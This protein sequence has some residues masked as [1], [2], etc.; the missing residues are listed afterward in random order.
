MTQEF[1]RHLR[2]NFPFYT[3][4]RILIAI[5]G[6]IDSVVLASL[7]RTVS[8][9]IALAHCNFAL[10]GEESDADEAFVKKLGGQYDIP[11]FTKRFDTEK[12][13]TSEKL[14][15]QMAA[16]ELRYNWF[17]QLM[18][19]HGYDYL[20]TAH[21]A[22]DNLETFL[23]NLSRGTGLDGLTGIPERHGKILRP[24][25]PFS[26]EEIKTYALNEK[27]EWRED[28]SNRENKYL[29]N[30]LRNKVIPRF[31]EVNDRLL[32]NVTKTIG[33]LK[34]YN[35]ILDRHIRELRSLYF[36]KDGNYGFRIPLGQLQ[37]LEPLESYL[38]AFFREY[39]F[40]AWDDV[41]NLLEAQ[42]GKF[43]LSP[44]HRLIRDRD[45]LLLQPLEE[46]PT[47]VPK[48]YKLQK[49]LTNIFDPLTL[50]MQE[51]TALG[52]TDEHT[53]YVDREKLKYPLIIRKWTEGDRFQPFG[54]KGSKK[55]S[56]FYKD[57]KYS[58][59]Q[60]ERQWLLCNGDDS[61]IWV[62]G[63]RADDRFRVT[64]KTKKILKI[65]HYV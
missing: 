59:D 65:S 5:S 46:G 53:I 56:K 64:D 6:G 21:H 22:D 4:S 44:T 42:S 32:S 2:L 30:Q 29:R 38:Y 54:L 13:A 28:S 36:I 33:Y 19:D 12:Y 58:L 20:M 41:K 15:T 8:E 26:R 23:I 27:L 9:N 43:L 7:M 50:Q 63:K 40:T 34:G 39:G 52:K 45:Y 16:R 55:L 31:K 1:H 3:N 14:S 25:L 51:V 61:I 24:L 17:D 62:I 18:S 10:R 57:E 11:V 47:R 49:E 37:K 60:K 35:E 48:V